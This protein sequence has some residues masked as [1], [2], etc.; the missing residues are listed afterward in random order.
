MPPESSRIVV[1]EYDD[2]WPALFERI[3]APVRRALADLRAE[4]EHVGS[5]AVP[6]LA[7]KPVIDIDVVVRAADDMPKAIERVRPLGYVHQGDQGIA[8]RE[9]FAWPPNGP[10][11]HVYA[12]VAGSKAHADHID[13]R[14]YLREHPNVADEYASLKRSL[15]SRHADDRL[16]Y[17]EAKSQFI[18]RVLAGAR[19]LQR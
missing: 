3:A 15:A 12:V 11:H 18:A 2:D 14:D 8:G 16:G 7:A 19:A 4:V 13:F 17:T 1:S 10:R 9:A 6:G 5:T